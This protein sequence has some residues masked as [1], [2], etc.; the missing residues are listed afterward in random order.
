MVC[1]LVGLS[2]NAGAWKDGRQL[3]AGRRDFGI[4]SHVLGAMG[5]F[6]VARLLD[7]N[8]EPLVGELDTTRGDVGRVQVKSVTRRGLSLI[9]RPQDPKD[10][11]YVLMLVSMHD[12]QVLGWLTGAEVKVAQFW[13]EAGHGV[14]A[15]AHFVPEEN[16]RPWDEFPI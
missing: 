11:F 7:R 4:E 2:R 15:T 3:E 5:E 9:V 14:H 13:R 8:W 12:A 1:G 16:L 10:A 6:A